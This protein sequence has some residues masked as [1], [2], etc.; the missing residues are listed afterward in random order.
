MLAFGVGVI[1][2]IRSA[3]RHEIARGDCLSLRRRR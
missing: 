3:D 1:A 2:R